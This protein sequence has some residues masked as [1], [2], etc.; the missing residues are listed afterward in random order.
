MTHKFSWFERISVTF[1]FL[2]LIGV[3]AAIVVSPPEGMTSAPRAILDLSER[4]RS[5]ILVSEFSELSPEAGYAG[6]K[7]G[8]VRPS[9]RL[10]EGT[11]ARIGYSLDA[12]KS[13]GVGVPR[14]LLPSIPRDMAKMAETDARKTLFLT[15][16]LPLVL[17]VNDRVL[18]DRT[19]VEQIIAMQEEG[20]HVPALERLWLTTIAE[21]YGLPEDNP[22]RLLRRLDVVPPSLALAQAAV[23]S[24]W[25]TSRFARDG[26]ALFGQWTTDEDRGLVPREREDDKAHRVKIFDHLI[27]SVAAYVHN[28]NTHK[29][30]A[31][32]RQKRAGLRRQD[33]PLDG[34]D[35]A[36]TLYRYSERG[37]DYVD[38][39]RLI[40][41]T[42]DL[43][44]LDDARLRGPMITA[45]LM[46]DD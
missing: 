35:L 45:M 41:N 23:E 39:L 9:V 21:K 30:Y 4:T 11:F 16:V 44:G 25:G 31:D 17:A 8:I 1:I 37:E 27:D 7:E 29:A 28:L 6:F 46:P 3:S 32:F 15:S 22:S 33:A 20:R 36:G 38:T 43:R 42:N 10:L 18:A 12:V 24:G 2:C 19:R 14:L 40:I 34:Y 5:E 26:N 13:G